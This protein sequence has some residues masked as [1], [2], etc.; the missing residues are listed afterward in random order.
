MGN[1]RPQPP[2]TKRPAHR[3]RGKARTA[4]GRWLDTSPMTV[5][6]VAET[7][8]VSPQLV[9]NLRRG[10][11]RPGRENAVR[12]EAL[13]LGAVPVSSWDKPRKVDA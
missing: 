13:T 7:L 2:L 12:I 5:K 6:V 3:P 11:A 10:H 4:F 8:G 1:R 9:Y